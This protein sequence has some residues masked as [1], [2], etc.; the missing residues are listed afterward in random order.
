M[1]FQQPS[2]TVNERVGANVQRFRKAAGMTQGELAEQLSQRGLSFQQQGILK[3]ERGSR[4]LRVDELL[5]IAEVLEVD[6]ESLTRQMD[7]RLA[8]LEQLSTA[9]TAAARCDAERRQHQEEVNRLTAEIADHEQRRQDAAKRLVEVLKAQG[10]PDL[11]Q[12]YT[13][14]PPVE[15]QIATWRAVRDGNH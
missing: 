5:I 14:L 3:V 1:S 15:E 13:N 9:E 6:Q 12:M 8:A 7:E 2:I 4:P 10:R 11:A